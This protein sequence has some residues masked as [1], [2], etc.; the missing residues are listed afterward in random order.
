MHPCSSLLDEIFV[1]LRSE[2]SALDAEDL[3]R[4]EELARERVAMLKEVWQ[5]R[6]GYDEALLRERLLTLQ[7]EQGRLTAK[8]EALQQKFRE[9]QNAGRKQA[10]YFNGD[11]HL[12][13]QTQ[14]AFYCDRQS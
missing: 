11:R 8:A 3:D 13:A 12:H 5:G 14:K 2:E 6:S 10:R 4:A 7:S 1:R 9:Q